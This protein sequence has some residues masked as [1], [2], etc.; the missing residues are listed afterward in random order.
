LK[1][2]PVDLFNHRQS[3]SFVN[4]EP[5]I[6]RDDPW[7]V[8]NQVTHPGCIN[9]FA[10]QTVIT[11][12]LRMKIGDTLRYK[13]ESGREL[14][15]RLAGGLANSV[16]QGSILISDSLLRA[17]YPASVRVRSLLIDLPDGGDENTIRILGERLRDQ[18]AVI[19]P[20]AERL[21]TFEAVENTYLDVFLMLG[22]LGLIIG[23]AGLAVMVMRSLRDRRRELALYAAL[24]FSPGMIY[25]LLAGEFLF[26]LLAGII[27][28]TI[29]ALTGTLPSVLGGNPVNLI[30]PVV[31]IAVV[32][33]N[34]LI[35]IHFPV[36][37][38]VKFLVKKGIRTM[39]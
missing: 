11:W 34:G 37:R 35:W 3:F 12:G 32:L 38:T 14:N 20:A 16:F 28:G 25:R 7:K 9:G 5:G 6:S 36:Q 4:L 33:I 31:L 30:F 26:I 10:D 29:A 2:I 15:I 23:T 22:G 17:H 13:D 39:G 8:L 19:T 18:G 24:G 1:G 27:S 21:S